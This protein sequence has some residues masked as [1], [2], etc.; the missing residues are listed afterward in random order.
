MLKRLSSALK[1]DKKKD[2]NDISA[3]NGTSSGVNGYHS[4]NSSAPATKANNNGTAAIVNGNGVLAPSRRSTFGFNKRS[5]GNS[6][7]AA[8]HDIER[9]DIDEMF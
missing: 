6:D 2:A 3:S 1:R 7:E 9:K 8:D 4:T 5:S